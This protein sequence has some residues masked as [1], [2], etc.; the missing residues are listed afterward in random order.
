MLTK[1]SVFCDKY[2]KWR[3]LALIT[4]TF[5]PCFRALGIS[6]YGFLIEILSIGDIKQAL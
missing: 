3:V 6:F 2:S 1:L 5:F 4:I